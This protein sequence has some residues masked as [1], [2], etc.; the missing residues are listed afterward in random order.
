MPKSETGI[1]DTG[2]QGD[3]LAR[4]ARRMASSGPMDAQ[5]HMA[6]G[7]MPMDGSRKAGARG[8]MNAA[9]FHPGRRRGAR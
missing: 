5:A 3:P 1:T 2:E 4:K 6:D 9:A 8:M 7:V